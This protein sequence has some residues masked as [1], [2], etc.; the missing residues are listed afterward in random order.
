MIIS[1]ICCSDSNI[2]NTD[3]FKNFLSLS[4][5]ACTNM[6]MSDYLSITWVSQQVLAP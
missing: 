3:D 4:V 2:T 1:D 5:T 6:F